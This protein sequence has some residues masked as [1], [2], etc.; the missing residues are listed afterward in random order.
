MKLSGSEKYGLPYFAKKL[1][2]I[3]ETAHYVG[4]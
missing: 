3:L 2:S 1:R 4:E